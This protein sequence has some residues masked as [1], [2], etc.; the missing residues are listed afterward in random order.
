MPQ[1]NQDK[2]S[3]YYALEQQIHHLTSKSC[4][5]KMERRVLQAAETTLQEKYS[6]DVK[7]SILQKIS[8][9]QEEAKFFSTVFRTSI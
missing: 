9:N 1:N 4:L 8:E 5:G 3:K 2:Y 7:H 6:A